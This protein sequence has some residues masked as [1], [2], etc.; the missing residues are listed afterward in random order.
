VERWNSF[1]AALTF[2][3]AVMEGAGFGLFAGYFW[4]VTAR[5]AAWKWRVD[6]KAEIE[7]KIRRYP[8][9]YQVEN[10]ITPTAKRMTAGI[11]IATD[12]ALLLLTKLFL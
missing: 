11:D 4:S 6:F 3:V 10:W 2:F 9:I 7:K 5:T 8:E 12:A 1:A